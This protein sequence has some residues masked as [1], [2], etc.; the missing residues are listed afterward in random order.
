MNLEKITINHYRSIESISISFPLNKPVILFGPNNAGKSNILSAINR[1]LGERYPTYIEMM[2]SDYFMR[3]K[4]SYP[5]TDISATFDSPLFYDKLDRGQRT[6]AV[7]YGNNGDRTD[8]LLH[9]GSGRR[10]YPTNEQRAVCQSYLI[11]AE[12]NIQSA[13]NYSSQYSLLSKFSRKIHEAL[14]SEHGAVAQWK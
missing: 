6:I 10:I 12:R 5:T 9:D 13:F 4:E 11:D 7:R 2:D 14:S 8:T 3:D 1:I